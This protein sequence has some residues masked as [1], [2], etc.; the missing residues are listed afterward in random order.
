MGNDTIAVIVSVG[1]VGATLGIG[2][3]SLIV[4]SPRA[5]RR[6]VAEL[7]ERI[8]HLEGM[9]AGLVRRGSP[10]REA[11]RPLETDRVEVCLR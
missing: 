1:A 4:P 8:A 6:G 2:L 3:A 11:E 10:G 7:R 5:L 9:F